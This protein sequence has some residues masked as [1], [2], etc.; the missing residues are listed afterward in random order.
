MDT[1]RF[2]REQ[3]GLIRGVI[4]SRRYLKLAKRV[5][6]PTHQVRFVALLA[7]IMAISRT[8]PRQ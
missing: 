4:T 2:E 1:G 6:E 7:R 3:R 8:R 5:A